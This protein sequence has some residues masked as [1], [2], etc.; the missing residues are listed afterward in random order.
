MGRYNVA[1]RAIGAFQVTQNSAVRGA[2]SH[3]G[4]AP[5]FSFNANLVVPTAVENRPRSIALLGCVK[6]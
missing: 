1:D 3:D 2:S 5:L 6:N 4:R